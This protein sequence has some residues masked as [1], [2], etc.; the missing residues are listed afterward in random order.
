MIWHKLIEHIDDDS[1]DQPGS[2]AS[3]DIPATV[4]SSD[5]ELPKDFQGWRY[6]R[7]FQKGP[8]AA[9]KHFISLSGLEVYGVVLSVISEELGCAS[10]LHEYV[11]NVHNAGIR[12]VLAKMVKGS[13]VVRG[14]DWQY[15][16]E[17]GDPPGVGIL[18]ADLAN[19]W[20]HVEWESGSSHC[21]RMGAQ[22]ACDLQLVRNLE[23]GDNASPVAF[24]AVGNCMENLTTVETGENDANFQHLHPSVR[25]DGCDMHPLVGPRFKCAVCINFDLCESCFNSGFHASEGHPCHRIERPGASLLLVPPRSYSART[26]SPA[27]RDVQ[28]SS[29]VTREGST[30][31]NIPSEKS[32]LSKL[33]GSVNSGA[34]GNCPCSENEKNYR[35][36]LFLS[37]A[38]QKSGHETEFINCR[39][40]GQLTVKLCLISSFK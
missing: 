37:I 7:I 4:V 34:D 1:L 29:A 26:Q 18:K 20:V 16:D 11:N 27:P 39:P 32:D 8:N 14:P 5:A 23:T 31:G 22:G 30:Q 10:D 6:I 24:S 19:G 12:K 15:G 36:T 21:Y 2:S 35:L 3:W 40:I 38:T 33:K 28:A 13:H 25:C 17:D 9:S